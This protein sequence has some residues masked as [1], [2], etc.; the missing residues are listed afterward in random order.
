MRN[1]IS[2]RPGYDPCVVTYGTIQGYIPFFGTS[3]VR[4]RILTEFFGRP[5][6]VVHVRELG[7]RLGIAPAI[8][9]RELARLET[10]GILRSELAGRSRRYSFD[11]GSA[12]A[13]EARSLFQ[14]TLGV[15]AM[16]ARALHDVPGIEDAF[17]FGS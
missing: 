3:Q 13:G 5:G 7:R 6:L 1:S 4:L 17:I 8:V 11:H 14:K 10:A 2:V 15:E 16:L 12:V 9:G